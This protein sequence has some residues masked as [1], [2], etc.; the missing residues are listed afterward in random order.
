MS[1]LR[2]ECAQF[3]ACSMTTW[4]LRRPIS[5]GQDSSVSFVLI[6]NGNRPH[7]GYLARGPQGFTIPI[8]LPAGGVTFREPTP[9]NTQYPTVD[10]AIQYEGLADYPANP[11]NLL[12]V[13]NANM[14]EQQLHPYYVDRSLDDPGIVNRGQYGDATYY[15]I[16][17]GILPLLTPWMR[18]C[19]SSWRLPNQQRCAGGRGEPHSVPDAGRVAGFAGQLTINPNPHAV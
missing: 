16:P 6:A 19:A 11:L 8:L 2:R 12:T 1:S 18:H 14:G 13:A 15:M 10:I 9:T 17:T 5:I 3:C 7:G 4:D